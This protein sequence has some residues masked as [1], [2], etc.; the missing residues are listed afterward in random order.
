MH[1]EVYR[2]IYPITIISIVAVCFASYFLEPVSEEWYT[3]L[4]KIVLTLIMAISIFLLI[5][6]NERES[7][8]DRALRSIIYRIPLR[9]TLLDR[10]EDDEL[11]DYYRQTTVSRVELVCD[12]FKVTWDIVLNDIYGIDG[13]YE[14]FIK[15]SWFY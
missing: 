5:S 9:Y 7:L 15:R 13:N 4:I 1:R 8:Y 3:K 11:Y 2:F 6:S 14:R 12:E 10:Y